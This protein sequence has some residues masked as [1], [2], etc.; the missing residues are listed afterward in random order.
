MKWNFSTNFDLTFFKSMGKVLVS[1]AANPGLTPDTANHA[2]SPQNIKQNP[3]SKKKE[4]TLFQT[5]CVHA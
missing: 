2:Q 4:K 5:F 1:C 3:E